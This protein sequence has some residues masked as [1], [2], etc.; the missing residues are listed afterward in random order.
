MPGTFELLIIIHV[1]GTILGVGAATFLEIFL[2]KSLADGKMEPVEGSFMKTTTTTLRVGL[3]ISVISGVGLIFMYRLNNQMNLL[4]NPILWAKFTILG[5]LLVN[6][7]LLQAHKIPLWAGSALS[8]VSWW[9]VFYYGMVSRGPKEP[10]IEL[11]FYYV[12]ALVVGA[13]LLE[14]LRRLHGIKLM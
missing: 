13:F 8:F 7:L 4:Y 12:I 14:G 5:V 2:N 1:V 10:Y 3:L 6:A 11:M 9:M